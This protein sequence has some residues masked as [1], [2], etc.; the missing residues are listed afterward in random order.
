MDQSGI[1]RA[2]VFGLPLVKKWDA[3]DPLEPR[4]YLD[5]NS[6]CYY[7]SATDHLVLAAFQSASGP[8]R[9]R[10]ASLICGLNPTDKHGVRHV[11]RMLERSDV[12]RGVG[13]VLL[14]HDDLTNLTNEERHGRITRR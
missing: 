6:R 7:Y 12:W 11:E 14:R 10:F 8:E 1:E 2:V 9:N 5:D 13:E 4:Y 3:Y